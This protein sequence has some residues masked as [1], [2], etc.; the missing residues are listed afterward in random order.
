[1]AD[2]YLLLLAP[3]RSLFLICSLMSEGHK[4]VNRDLLSKERPSKLSGLKARFARHATSYLGLDEQ[5]PDQRRT[6]FWCAGY[7][8]ADHGRLV[9]SLMSEPPPNERGPQRLVNCLSLTRA[10]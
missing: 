10:R 7:G 6:A 4:I 2:S 3:A 9:H 5:S 1:M 8:R